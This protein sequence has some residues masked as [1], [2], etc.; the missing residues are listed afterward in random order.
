MTTLISAEWYK[1]LRG[2][3]LAVIL[4][5]VTA[6]TLIQV[7][8]QYIDSEEP[9]IPG[10]FGVTAPADASFLL[11]VWLIAFVGYFIAS[12][13]QN[14]TMRNIL[15]LG[16]NRTHVYLSKVFSA[17]IAIAAIYLAV[18]IVAT[19]GFSAVSGFGDMT[20]NEFWRFFAWNFS[21]EILYHLPFAAI[22][23]M[24]AFLSRSLGMTILLGIGYWIVMLF[25]PGLLSMMGLDF[26]VEYLPQYYI[27]AFKHLSGDPAFIT[28]GII[29]SAAYIVI[30]GIIGCIVFKKSD[31]R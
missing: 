19:A 1:L 18:S 16:K 9:L 2:K 3:V 14:G 20:F 4:A 15:A 13:F 24:L 28:K 7:L 10:Q 29:V 12:E 17:F 31:I 30:T 21:M 26:A 5:G 22:F 27:G 6:Q 8:G 11:Q 23:T 25:L